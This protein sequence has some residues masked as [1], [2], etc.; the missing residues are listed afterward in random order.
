MPPSRAVGASIKASCTATTAVVSAGGQSC[1]AVSGIRTPAPLHGA[2]GTFSPWQSCG[3]AVDPTGSFTARVVPR[4]FRARLELFRWV[5]VSSIRVLQIS[6]DRACNHP[7]GRRGWVHRMHK[8][9][10][11]ETGDFAPWNVPSPYRI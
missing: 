4:L 2:W 1:C 3:T 8:Y 10:N 9:S 11:D 5:R 7:V 6:F